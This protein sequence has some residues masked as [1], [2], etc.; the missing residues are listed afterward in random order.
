MDFEDDIES[1][2]LVSKSFSRG[3]VFEEQEDDWPKGCYWA[4]LGVFFNSD[5]RGSS[6]DDAGQ[7][8]KI[9]R[10][11]LPCPSVL[12]VIYMNEFKYIFT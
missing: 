8:C 6:N 7:I 2:K 9:K 3:Y 4:G 5:Y 10:K 11:Q 1:C 12:A